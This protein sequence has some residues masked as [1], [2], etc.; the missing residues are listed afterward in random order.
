MLWFLWAW[1]TIDGTNPGP[2]SKDGWRECVS[3]T[4]WHTVEVNG[5]V[6]LEAVEVCT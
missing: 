3:V 1:L 4:H 2:P 5:V 6:Y